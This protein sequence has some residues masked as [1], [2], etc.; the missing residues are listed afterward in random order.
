MSVEDPDPLHAGQVALRR[1]GWAQGRARFLQVLREVRGPEVIFREAM[2]LRGLAEVALVSR[3]T[4]EAL[5]RLDQATQALGRLELGERAESTSG[6]ALEIRASIEAT[7]AEALFQDGRADQAW[8]CLDH[9]RHHLG[10]RVGAG[11]ASVLLTG[12]RLALRE[13]R[14]DVARQ[15]LQRVLDGASIES[16]RS[17]ILARLLLAD[18]HSRASHAEPT[19]EL[20]SKALLEAR[21][22][23]EPGLEAHVA[24]ALGAA[25]LEHTAHSEP[26]RLHS[27][28]RMVQ[29]LVQLVRQADAPTLPR[30]LVQL[31]HQARR[32]RRP[33]LAL[34]AAEVARRAASAGDRTATHG[35]ALRVIVKALDAIGDR[36]G[37]AHAAIAREQLV[38]PTQP[39][40]REVA[41]WYRARR[42][43]LQGYD[44]PL[45]L[46]LAEVRR[47]VEAALLDIL[48][49]EGGEPAVLDDVSQGVAL[50]A[51]VLE[52]GEHT[53]SP[54]SGPP[55]IHPP[56]T[57]IFAPERLDSGSD[58]DPATR[59]G[60]LVVD[61][62]GPSKV[63]LLEQPRTVV[64]RGRRADIQVRDDARLS[65]RHFVVVR[66][67]QGY[68]IEDLSPGGQTRV[69]ERPVLAP[70]PLADGDVIVAGESTFRFVAV[71][72]EGRPLTAT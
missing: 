29:G 68:L 57:P 58:G 6:R 38:G 70:L 64:G 10:D 45:S 37:A 50:V 67:D 8:R 1:G 19:I 34:T 39:H 3:D 65:R 43:E 23:G 28:A 48:R 17:V 40:A 32:H 30:S 55:S 49:A 11:V 21:E 52:R 13:G 26:D 24:I 35:Q 41:D 22:L 4:H 7:R 20:L 66:T 44:R 62:S 59:L 36:T 5:T 54:S 60:A 12:G 27:L 31:A 56:E 9:A 72:A 69:G 25:E 71:G 14:A 2:A 63:L 15:W 47:R 33:L 61:G 53:P 46:V 16:Q 42:P 51:R 18:M